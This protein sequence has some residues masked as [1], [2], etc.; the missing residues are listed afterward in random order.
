MF[1]SLED[2][3]SS[4]HTLSLHLRNDNLPRAIIDHRR[5]LM[6]LHILKLS[7]CYLLFYLFFM[8]DPLKVLYQIFVIATIRYVASLD[9]CLLILRPKSNLYY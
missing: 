9:Q 1:W 2:Y 8:I 4:E 3:W 7:H 5:T 6:Y